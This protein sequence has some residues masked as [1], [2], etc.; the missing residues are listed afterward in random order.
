MSDEQTGEILIVACVVCD[1]DVTEAETIA[2]D[3]TYWSDGAGELY[4]YCPE[5]AAA[6]SAV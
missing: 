6:S 2:Q 3:W 5:C 1:R 4:P